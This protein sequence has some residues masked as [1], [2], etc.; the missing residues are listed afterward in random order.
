[1]PGAAA[2]ANED[3]LGF[4][5]KRAIAVV[6]DGMGGLMAGAEADRIAVDVALEC[7]SSATQSRRSNWR[8][9]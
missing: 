8:M 6:A 1:M 4:D 9:P 3:A 5:S 7:L 2:D